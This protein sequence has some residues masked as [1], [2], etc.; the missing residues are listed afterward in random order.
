MKLTVNQLKTLIRESLREE[1]DRNRLREDVESSMPVAILPHNEVKE[2]IENIPEVTGN[3]PPFFFPVGYIKELNFEIPAKF[4]GGR[5][6]EGEPRV[7][8]FKCSEM[9]VYT[10]A[11]YESLGA[12]KVMRRE[13][14]RERSGERTGFSFDNDNAVANRIGVSARGEE[15]L[16]CYIKKG[17]QPKVKYFISLDDEDLREASRQ[18]V[19]QY[20]TP[21]QANQILNGRV[22]PENPREA[23]QPV[24]RLKLSGIYRIGNLGSSVM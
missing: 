5:G 22:A 15:Q 19:A 7:R 12:T 4:K 10:G 8:I 21:A 13:T 1:L 24:V 17:T 20:L 6:S 18:E 11:D 14:G 16:Q 23:G 3:R 2:Y 9:T